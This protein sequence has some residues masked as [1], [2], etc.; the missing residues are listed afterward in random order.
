[1]SELPLFHTVIS[2]KVIRINSSNDGYVFTTII[3][4][5]PDPYSKPPVVKVRSRR[6]LA[7]IDS[8]VTELVCRISGFERSFKYHDKQTGQPSV[9]YNVEMFLDLVE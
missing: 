4:P 6:K 2:G 7:S 5:A 1:M 8:E 3:L 9:G